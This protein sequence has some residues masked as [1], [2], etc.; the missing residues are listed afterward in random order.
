MRRY[1][2][3]FQGDAFY[4]NLKLVEEVKKVAAK[5]N[6]TPAQIA[7]AWVR[8]HSGKAGFPTIIPI[9]GATTEARVKE[10]TKDI[11]LTQT[12]LMELNSILSKF[13]VVGDRYP[14]H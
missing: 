3:R 11:S 13:S 1:Y 2:P 7:I 5:K 6:V 8:A 9:P 10:N 14:A 4:E 12:E